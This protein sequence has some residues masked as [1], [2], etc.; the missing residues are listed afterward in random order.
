MPSPPLDE[1]R[2]GRLAKLASE[3]E[4]ARK[5]VAGQTGKLSK[6][7]KKEWQDAEWLAGVT[8]DAERGRA[9][10]TF[11]EA[12]A[13]A[14]RRR[15]RLAEV[16]REA[17]ELLQKRGGL[18]KPSNL[19]EPPAD[20][21]GAA[22]EALARLKKAW[23]GKR[24]AIEAQS[25][26]DALAAAS[27]EI[28]AAEADAARSRDAAYTAADAT[29][30]A[31]VRAAKD[32]FGGKLSRVTADR[33]RLLAGAEAKAASRREKI[34]GEHKAAF[35][36]AEGSLRGEVE[37]TDAER[38]S[39]LAPARRTRDDAIKDADEQR[40]AVRAEVDADWREAGDLAGD[41]PDVAGVRIG[42]LDVDAPSLTAGRRG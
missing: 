36:A 7:L 2:D 42:V 27:A 3:M 32:E 25:L 19:V 20:P 30:D 17:A 14:K 12:A 13:R 34:E 21:D 40:D 16:E 39:T 15:S 8:R 18:P 9:D 33:D 23:L 29:H 1:S 22:G 41:L 26:A 37:A 38:E 35:D 24:K 6:S 31:E 4:A 10:Q 5:S 28:D 11:D